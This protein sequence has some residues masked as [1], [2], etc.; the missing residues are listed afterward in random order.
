MEWLL[1]RKEIDTIYADH[2]PV[3]VPEIVARAQAKKLVEWLAKN[4][5]S[6]YEDDQI[7]D[8]GEPLYFAILWEDWLQLRKEV[9]SE[10]ET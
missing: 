6:Y 5:G 7:P 3:F 1:T 9:I 10:L 8:K 2:K 4:G